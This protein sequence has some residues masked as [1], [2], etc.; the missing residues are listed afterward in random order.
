MTIETK[1]LKSVGS[2][3]FKGILSTATVKVPTS[4]YASYKKLFD[5]KGLGKK[6]SIV[7]NPVK[8]DTFTSGNNK[9]KVTSSS[10]VTFTGLKNT[11]KT[12]MSIPKTVTFGGKTF[13][14]TAITEKALKGNT[15]LKKATIG[16]NVKVIGASAFYGCKNLKTITIKST[17]LT[18][19]AKNALKGIN[20][21][22][23]I[24]VPAKKL[25]AYKK[26]L[27]NKGQGKKVTI[28]KIK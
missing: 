7:I 14:V 25:S 28:E 16:E 10:A 4:K 24:K 13:K 3:A 19:V 17:K 6:N 12:E 26:L 18:S 23:T 15:K 22:A 21:K 5:G 8:G 11:K 2:K 9:Y 27:K 1:S 20:A